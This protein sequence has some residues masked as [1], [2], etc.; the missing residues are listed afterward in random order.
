[1]AEKAYVQIQNKGV[2]TNDLAVYWVLEQGDTATPITIPRYSDRTVHIFGTFGGAS[3]SLEGSIDPAGVVYGVLTDDDKSDITQ[4]A[5]AAPRVVIPNVLTVK[6]T[7]TGG[8]GSTSI[9]IA[10]MA[11]GRA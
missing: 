9:T 5:S 11:H 6:P 1:M 4:T 10:L 8:D 7:I 3:V 2:R